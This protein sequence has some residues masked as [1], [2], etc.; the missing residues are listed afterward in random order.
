MFNINDRKAGV[1]LNNI[2]CQWIEN[3]EINDF[4]ECFLPYRDSNGKVKE[5][6]NKT[7]EIFNMD[8]RTIKRASILVGYCDGPIYD[9]GIGFEIGYAVTQNIPIIL[10]TTD[11][12]YNEIEGRL[13]SISPLAEKLTK[14]IHEREDTE[15]KGDY[16][17]GLADIEKHVF[18]RLKEELNIVNKKSWKPE[19]VTS[20]K[21]IYIDYSFRLN[22]THRI[23]EEEL[24]SFLD[25]NNISYYLADNIDVE[26]N[27]RYLYEC[28]MVVIWGDEFDFYFDS[29]IIQGLSYGWKKKVLLYTST[30]IRYVQF[31]DFVLYKNPMIEHSAKIIC[32]REQLYDEVIKEMP[33]FLS[34][35][36]NKKNEE[37]LNLC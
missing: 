22:D 1:N 20:S 4:E 8:C 32:K 16:E 24:R 11:Y 7:L 23:F 17:K 19:I 25:K 3:K 35:E 10:L 18:V 6:K 2:L 37:K 12:F 21:D 30:R 14:V 13:F 36:N 33:H 28:K 9:S 31:Q 5:L 15:F 34:E 26:T 29:A 27:L